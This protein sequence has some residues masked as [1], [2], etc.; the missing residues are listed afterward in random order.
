MIDLSPAHLAIVE[1]ILAEHVPECEVQA[2]GSRA[3]WNAKDYSDLDLAVIGEGPL[4]REAI[5]RLKEAFEESRLPMRVDVVDWHAIAD[6]FR[7]AIE[8]ECVVV[9]KAASVDDWPSVRLRGVVQVNPP[10]PLKRGTHAPFV[11]MADVREHDRRLPAL[12]TREF[13]GGGARFRNGDTLLARITPSLENGKTAWVSGLSHGATGH[14]STEFIVMSGQEGLTDPKFVYY[15]ARSPDFRNYAIGQMTGTSG[16]QRVPT[17]AVEDFEFLLPPLEEQ[18][19]IARVLGALDDKIELNRRMSETLEAMARA[20]F[21][22]WFVDFD[23]VRAKAEGRPSGLPPDL[24]ALFAASFETLELGEIPAGWEVKALGDV[25]EV[26]PKRTIKRGDVATHVEMAALPISGPHVAYWTERPFT[27]GSR[28]I[29]GDTLLA[30]ITPSLE[31]GKT[32]FVDFLDDGET[33]WGSTEFIVLR[34][35][36][37]WPPEMAYVMAREADF[38]EHAV[39]NM[40]G[41]SGRQR[42]PAEA[43]ATY[44]LAVP[45]EGV[46]EAYGR[47]VR[48]FF[49]R[50]TWL[51]GESRSLAAQRDALIPRLVSGKLR[52][53]PR[54]SDRAMTPVHADTPSIVLR[55]TAVT[56]ADLG[57]PF[58]ASAVLNL[59]PRPRV[60]IECTELDASVQG[61][62]FANS[63]KGSTIALELA[64]GEHLEAFPFV[65]I[66]DSTG[67]FVPTSG[68]VT[69]LQTGDDIQIASFS[70]LNFPDFLDLTTAPRVHDLP[71]EGSSEM[72]GHVQLEAPPWSI[73][74]T[75]VPGRDRIKTALRDHGYA[76]THEGEAARL[77]GHTFTVSEATELFD[78]L[79]GFLSFVRGARS[80]VAVVTGT[81]AAG[82]EVWER[83]GAAGVEDRDA[84]ESWFHRLHGE[85][86]AELFPGYWGRFQNTTASDPVRMATEWY[87]IG[88]A[89]RNAP[90][91][92]ILTQAAIE[93]LAHEEIGQKSRQL[94][95]DWIASALRRVGIDESLPQPFLQSAFWQQGTWAHGPHALVKTRNDL[96]HANMT[97][98][99]LSVNEYHQ[100]NQ[101][102]LWYAELML[103]HAFEYDGSYWNRL[104]QEFE[105]VPWATPTRGRRA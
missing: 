28:F 54:R 93:R 10:R 71:E 40:T 37:P 5:A 82:D 67:R 20:L 58:P 30:R 1:R 61:S 76:I 11:A 7:E 100:V 12:D 60:H 57:G 23:P 74:I 31:N 78:C 44:S 33:G 75:S 15:L 46:V 4:P 47:V 16:R 94:E 86:L 9:Q 42:V 13:K 79:Q 91:G 53:A 39:V 104:T 63:L 21:R 85:I 68:P 36:A 29:L 87:L 80:G 50:A 99:A 103:L 77:D 43:V 2:F 66:G 6:G 90:T 84:V 64:T 81:G 73:R 8:S 45:S 34:P 25:I 105:P 51:R 70:I 38:R 69:A 101:L 22:S 26:N 97:T 62:L 49:E 56:F 52:T 65:S 92:I 35:K 32:A 14:G 3:T 95:G 17:D 89:Q 24:D 41:T 102:G 59:S 27:S 19:A 88:N 98:G 55:D 83:W 48:P 72:L 96:V 18:R